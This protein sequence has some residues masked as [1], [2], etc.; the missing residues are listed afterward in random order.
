[1]QVRA[2]APDTVFNSKWSFLGAIKTPVF[3]TILNI[4]PISDIT[5]EAV[6]VSWVTGGAAVTSIKILKRSDSSVV[7]TVTLTPTDVTNQYRII[8]GLASS[9]GYIIFLYSGNSVRGWT[10]FDTKAPMTGNLI[11][12]R[13]ITGRP[14]VLSDTIPLIA[15]GSTVILKRGETYNIGAAL[16]ISKSI[17]IVSGTDLMIPG[18]AIISMPNNFNITS[19]SVI[20]YI[21]FNDVTLRGTDYASK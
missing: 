5:E 15:S 20:D 21:I 9:T 10:D 18:Q 13:N 8:N 12:L 17:T 3:P 16:N 11:D 4:P 6:K 1:M 14:S 19:G 7:T 2:N